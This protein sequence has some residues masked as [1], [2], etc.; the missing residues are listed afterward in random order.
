MILFSDM[1]QWKVLQGLLNLDDSKHAMPNALHQVFPNT[2][3]VAS[4]TDLQREVPVQNV[5]RHGLQLVLPPKSDSRRVAAEGGHV[6]RCIQ[7]GKMYMSK[8]S[9]TRHMKFMCRKEPQLQCPHCP[10]R[11]KCDT[12]LLTHIY[13]KHPENSN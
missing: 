3:G 8:G 5:K 1:T 10:W 9:L 13:C 2:S 11:T 4:N 12:S 7:C 6:F